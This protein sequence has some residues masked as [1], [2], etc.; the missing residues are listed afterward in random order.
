MLEDI[1]KPNFA[2]VVGLGVVTAAL[3]ALLPEWRP[4]IKS[5]IKFVITLI[6]EAE[7]EAEAELVRALVEGTIA[8]I[9]GEMEK[10]AGDVERRTAVQRRVRRFK[11]RAA[12]HA[13]RWAD[14]EHDRRL[15]YERH[16]AHLEA[17]L[18]HRTR[19]APAREHRII[20]DAVAELR[21][22]DVPGAPQVAAA[23]PAT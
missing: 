14:G 10:P 19:H 4:G 2:A 20:E 17:A 8:A 9:R 3:P 11:R 15:R 6:A 16:V 1:A 18:R 5:A 13:R 22:E 12:T 21:S 23:H 7:G